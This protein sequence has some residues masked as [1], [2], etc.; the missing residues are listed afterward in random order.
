MNGYIGVVKCLLEFQADPNMKGRSASLSV[1]AFSY[2][3]TV[4]SGGWVPLHLA[5][6]NG[7]LEVAEYLLDHGAD[8]SIKSVS[9]FLVCLCDYSWG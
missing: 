1:L 6:N 2:M 3:Y 4:D 8:P 9:F 5:C 7:R